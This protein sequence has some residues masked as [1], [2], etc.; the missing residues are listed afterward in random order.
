MSLTALYWRLPALAQAELTKPELA[1][2]YAQFDADD[3]YDPFAD[4]SEFDEAQEEE[5]DINFFRNGRFLT[6]GLMVGYRGFTGTLGNLYTGNF[7]YGIALTYFFDLRFA[8]QVGYT[9]SSH[10]FSFTTG[11]EPF[12]GSITIQDIQLALKYYVNT[13]NVTKGLG[14]FNPYILVGLSEMIQTTN[15]AST[16]M[17]GTDNATGFDLGCGIEM[18]MMRNK[19]FWGAQAMF[20]MVAWPYANSQLQTT[21]NKD[22]GIYPNGDTYTV[23]GLIG[24]NF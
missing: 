18:P 16:S 3:S 10:S 19:M 8:M 11:G 15:V 2:E 6:L 7:D 13:Q 17:Y 20:Q 1:S 24:V 22:T 12:G 21:N 14:Q 5:E 4:Y 23:T 9:T